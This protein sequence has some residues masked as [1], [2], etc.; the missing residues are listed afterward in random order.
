MAIRTLLRALG[1][2]Y[3]TA[4][5]SFGVQAG[6]L[7]GSRGIL[8]FA[9]YFRAARASLGAAA[10]WEIPSILWLTWSDRALAAVWI[11]GAVCA[12]LAAFG[13]YQ[14]VAL[15]GCLVLWLSLCSAGQDFLSYQWDVL[16]LEAGFLAVFADDSPVRVW[17]F[18]WL[19][20]RLMFFSGA[21]KLL[22]GDPA[23]RNL[24]ALDYHYETQPLPTPL[25]WYAYQLPMAFQR[26]STLFV[27]AAELV[28]PLLFFGPRRF[29]HAGAGA[30]ILLQLL[31]LVTG[32]YT[33]FN[34]LTITLA[35]F[36]FVEPKRVPRGRAHHAVTS[37]LATFVGLT[38]G[39][40]LL[41]LFNLALPPGGGAVLHA[42]APLR[43]I[44]SYG[45]FTVMTV[46]RPE[47]V[48][49]GSNDGVHWLAYEFRY[50]P[51]GVM[52][53]PP[54]VAPH[55]PRLDWQMW[56]AALGTRQENPWFTRFVIRLLEGEGSVLRLLESNPFPKAPPKYIRARIFLYHFTHFGDRPWWRRED[57]GLYFPPASLP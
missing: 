5:V 11:L 37:A 15:A 42:I 56:F 48:V 54:V 45:L 40:L 22:S 16:L 6:G 1:A 57:E 36:L 14:R 7:I 43:I 10:Y 21:G 12:I 53:A 23:W 20:F 55:Q 51:G 8:P 33:F 18:R 24:T 34:F 47:I 30:V 2:V 31:I 9:A 38:S 41:E 26:V 3:F 27:F 49:E 39:L 46:Q 17:L 29:R 19:A 13:Y 25:A 28:A 4:F 35:L 44:N 32:N 50:K 52:R